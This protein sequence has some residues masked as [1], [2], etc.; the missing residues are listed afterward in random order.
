MMNIMKAQDDP[1]FNIGFMGEEYMKSKYPED[2]KFFEGEPRTGA[3]YSDVDQTIALNPYKALDLTDPS[4]DAAFSLGAG[5][6]R[7]LKDL[8]KGEMKLNFLE[9][10]PIK[11]VSNRFINEDKS[12]Q[13]NILAHEM[14]H[15]GTL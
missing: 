15:Y 13:R 10:V 8:E 9:D 5:K 1:H 2:D 12:R 6:P 3:Y 11:H 4:V 7:T 14:G